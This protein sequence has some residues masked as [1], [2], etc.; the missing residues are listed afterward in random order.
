MY[1]QDN[2][3][4]RVVLVINI[5]NDGS[6]IKVIKEFIAHLPS[7]PNPPNLGRSKNWLLE[8]FAP[9]LSPPF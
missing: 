4:K 2:N 8:C 6:L 7:P 5:K 1:R 9:L 3:N